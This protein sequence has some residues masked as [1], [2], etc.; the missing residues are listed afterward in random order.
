MCHVYLCICVCICVRIQNILTHTTIDS[1]IH[2]L[3]MRVHTLI[4]SACRVICMRTC[5]TRLGSVPNVPYTME[6]RHVATYLYTHA[7]SQTCSNTPIYT[8]TFTL[9][10]LHTY[11][12]TQTCTCVCLQD[13]C[14]NSQTSL[15][16]WREQERHVSRHFL[17]PGRVFVFVSARM[18]LCVCV[19]CAPFSSNTSDVLYVCAALTSPALSLLKTSVLQFLVRNFGSAI[20]FS[21]FLDCVCDLA[22]PAWSP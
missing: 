12:Y 9:K 6:H 14:A 19:F 17:Q 7:H 21:D 5:L 4:L 2:G 11:I 10:H 16:L 13:G 20:E 18:H 8:Y 3:S 1:G 15:P 22:C